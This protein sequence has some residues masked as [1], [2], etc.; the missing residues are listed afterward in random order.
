MMK[1]EKVIGKILRRG[2]R[3]KTFPGSGRAVPEFPDKEFREVFVV[4]YRVIHEL[5]GNSV[6]ILAVVHS[7]QILKDLGA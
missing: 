5:A 2:G 1:A 7:S 3:L 4:K 6:N